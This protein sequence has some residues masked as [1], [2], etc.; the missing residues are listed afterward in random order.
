[1]VPIMWKFPIKPWFLR[2]C[3]ILGGG[4]SKFT[5]FQISGILRHPSL[6]SDHEPWHIS[7][8]GYHRWSLRQQRPT[9]WPKHTQSCFAVAQK[10]SSPNQHL[11]RCAVCSG[12]QSSIAGDLYILISIFQLVNLTPAASWFQWGSESHSWGWTVEH[13][14]PDP[15][16]RSMN[17]SISCITV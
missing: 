16:L 12:F 1:M 2:G 8:A 9:Y 7:L 10:E 5:D 6:I 4:I 17:C 3:L 15:T 13:G 11:N 14:T